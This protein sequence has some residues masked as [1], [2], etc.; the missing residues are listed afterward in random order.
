MR[1][2]TAPQTYSTKSIKFSFQS[3]KEASR[4]RQASS[5]EKCAASADFVTLAHAITA[6]ACAAQ[7]ITRR[8]L[9]SRKPPPAGRPARIGV[10]C[11]RPSLRAQL[12]S[13]ARAID[14]PVSVPPPRSFRARAAPGDNCCCQMRGMS[15]RERGIRGM[16]C[17]DGVCFTG[18]WLVS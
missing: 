16:D 4:K 2:T 12:Q 18:D 1:N 15:L 8:N 10:P 6:R 14:S 7:A 17:N 9:A 5:G 11:S 13:C 3:A